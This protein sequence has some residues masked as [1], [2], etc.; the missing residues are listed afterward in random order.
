MHS[1][2]GGVWPVMLTPFT[3]DGALDEGGLRA[4][5]DWY[6]QSGVNGLFSACQSSEILRLTL[7]ERVAH[8]RVTVEAA[9]GRVPVIA[10]GHVSDDMDEQTRELEAMADT[11]VD[12]VILI[13][14]HLAKPDE[15]DS[16]WI[17]NCETLIKRLGDGIR[18]GLYECPLPYKR[19]MTKETLR[20][21]PD[22]GRF[23]FLKDTCC[24]AKTIA[25]RLE[26][27]RNSSLRLYNANSTTLL[28]SLREGAA[29]FSGVMA[30]FH[31]ELYVWL[32]AHPYHQNAQA[33]QD[34]LAV[35]SL[36]ERQLYPVNA[37]YHLKAI[38]KL[39]VETYSRVCDDTLLS[40]TFKAEV[41]MMDRLCRDAYARYCR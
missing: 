33:V 28:A 11:G 25:D 8:A 10:S 35:C 32:T 5:T 31:P 29:G 9:K 34:I 22:T 23:Y 41:H 3:K 14:N 38:E 2:P 37:K 13:T 6:I 4:L 40:D 1:Y 21:C 20:F 24:D 7:K 36:I 19:L 30:G 17:K 15:P 16:V 27:L 26:T 39:P 12:A 18:L